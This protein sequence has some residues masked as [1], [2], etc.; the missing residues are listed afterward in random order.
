MNI[1]NEMVQAGY[2]ALPERFKYVGYDTLR[3]IFDAMLSAAPQ[4]SGDWQKASLPWDDYPIGTKARQSGE[5]GYW[6]KNERG[7]KWHNGATF[8]TPGAA[9]Q[10]MLSAAPIPPEVEPVYQIRAI[11]LEE[12]IGICPI[13]W[14]DSTREECLTKANHQQ[15]V[16]YTSPPSPKAEGTEP[17]GFV[18]HRVIQELREGKPG[19]HVIGE[20]KSI[21][22]SEPIYTSPPTADGELRKA[23]KD[24]CDWWFD[25]DSTAASANE[26]RLFNRLAAVLN[27]GKSC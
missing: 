7:W 25:Q 18:N 1:T 27:N 2:A 16:L 15:R 9:N 23:V 17:V 13:I 22:Y 26:D 5:G 14:I 10:V 12:K 3:N 4:V 24:V 20:R 21:L 6:I 8:P 19:M 11:G